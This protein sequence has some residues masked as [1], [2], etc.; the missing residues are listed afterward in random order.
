MDIIQDKNLAILKLKSRVVS[1]AANQGRWTADFK[2]F[3]ASHIFEGIFES[4]DA[5]QIMT[6]L[7]KSCVTSPEEIKSWVKAYT[8]YGPDG[9][10]LDSI[11]TGKRG[12]LTSI[13]LPCPEF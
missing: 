7:D 10:K 6:D 9:L 2:L 13:P 4:V 3:V 11:P 5:A 1:I 12:E 8:I